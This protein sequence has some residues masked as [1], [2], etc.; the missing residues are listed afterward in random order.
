[1]TGWVD[2]LEAELHANHQAHVERV[3]VGLK[4]KGFGA[5]DDTDLDA[6]LDLVGQHPELRAELLPRGSAVRGG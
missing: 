1:M 4:A 5:W 3:T 2:L 6:Y